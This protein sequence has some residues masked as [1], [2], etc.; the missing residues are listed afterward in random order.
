MQFFFPILMSVSLHIEEDYLLQC[1]N[2][3][4]L[5]FVFQKLVRRGLRPVKV[6]LK[7]LV[8]VALSERE[9]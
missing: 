6:G 8:F 7:L 2:R 9:N 4:K 1:Q 3:C 5:F